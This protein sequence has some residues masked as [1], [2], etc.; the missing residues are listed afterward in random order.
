MLKL[1]T[2]P[3][4]KANLKDICH[5][6]GRHSVRLPR[7]GVPLLSFRSK[8]G[9]FLSEDARSYPASFYERHQVAFPFLPLKC[10]FPF[11]QALCLQVPFLCGRAIY[12]CGLRNFLKKA[13]RSDYPAWFMIY[14]KKSGIRRSGCGMVHKTAL[15]EWR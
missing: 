9:R 5:P 11:Q 13:L 4:H 14:G 6:E 7:G 12:T 10:L 15:S 8:S 1:T 2:I 3:L